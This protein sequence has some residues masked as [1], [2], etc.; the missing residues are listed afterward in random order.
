MAITAGGAWFL[1]IKGS[2]LN[3]EE[4]VLLDG[5]IQAA[6]T[7][8]YV[9]AACNLLERDIDPLRVPLLRLSAVSTLSTE[10]LVALR[11][12]RRRALVQYLPTV[13]G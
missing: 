1:I 7:Y 11:T 12:L 13:L 4:G 2:Y 6:S 3:T 10:L 9:L 8:W 5:S